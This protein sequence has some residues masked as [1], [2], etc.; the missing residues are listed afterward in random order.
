MI[1]RVSVTTPVTLL[2]AENNPSMGR[3][4]NSS[5]ARARWSHV[6]KPVFVD[7]DLDD[8]GEAP[9][10][11]Q[12]VGVVLVGLDEDH[13]PLLDAKLCR[14]AAAQ[15]DGGHGDPHHLVQ[16]LDGRRRLAPDMA[17]LCVRVAVEAATVCVEVG[18]GRTW[19]LDKQTLASRIYMTLAIGP[20]MIYLGFEIYCD[21]HDRLSAVVN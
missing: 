19:T 17:V 3:L 13:P 12:Q 1:R 21:G 2:Q 15:L 4:A 16:P 18:R 9:T 14:D 20:L 8:L 7:A 11:R 6:H 5:D 10:P